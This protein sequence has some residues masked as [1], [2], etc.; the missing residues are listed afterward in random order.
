VVHAERQQQFACVARIEPSFAGLDF[1]ERT[2]CDPELVGQLLT[3][4]PIRLAH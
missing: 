4:E 3:G 1:R 2:D